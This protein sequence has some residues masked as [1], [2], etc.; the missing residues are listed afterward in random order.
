M[1]EINNKLV[2]GVVMYDSKKLASSR[3][4]LDTSSTSCLGGGVVGTEIAASV[5]AMAASRALLLPAGP[6]AGLPE[7]AGSADAGGNG[8]E[9]SGATVPGGA[10]LK[11]SS[12]VIRFL[13]SSNSGGI[14]HRDSFV[15]TL[16]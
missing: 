3:G 5:A 12:L 14:T 15:F 4:V 1:L 2:V 8:L 10:L 16:W 11:L 13:I 9:T 7:S 6:G